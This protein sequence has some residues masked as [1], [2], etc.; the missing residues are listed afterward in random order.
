M[1]QSGSPPIGPEVDTTPRPLPARIPIRGQYVTLEPLHRRH[2][3]ELWQAAQ[4]ADESWTYLGYGPFASAEAMARQVGDLASVHDRLVWAARPVTTG[5]VSGWLSLLDIEPRNAAIELGSIWFGPR[6]QRTRAA[7]EAIYLLLK[8][9]AD[10][11]G[12]RRLVWKCNAL[13]APSKRAAERLGFTYEGRH[14]MHMVVKGHLRDTDWYSIV[15]DEWPARRDALLAWLDAANF[16]ADGS[17]LHGLA[18]LRARAAAGS[19]G[20]VA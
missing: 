4:G 16:G 10:D 1:P 18:E 19:S 14:R 5:V 17:A 7:T 8:L 2:A 13:N 9:A 15:G 3:A 12:Y 20:Q 6:M 11:L